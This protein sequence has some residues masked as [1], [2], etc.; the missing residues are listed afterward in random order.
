MESSFHDSISA[1]LQYQTMGTKGRKRDVYRSSVVIVA[2]SPYKYPNG[3]MTVVI[4]VIKQDGI[5]EG[6]ALATAIEA[7][8]HYVAGKVCTMTLNAHRSTVC[9]D[10]TNVMCYY[11]VGH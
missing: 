3:T 5:L 7:S 2:P 9:C 8:K 6:K 1:V 11:Q 10:N 4:F